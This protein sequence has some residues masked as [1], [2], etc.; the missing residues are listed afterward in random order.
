M[1]VELL[2]RHRL[3]VDDFHRMA[4]AGILSGDDRVELI[5]GELIDMAPIGTRHA[6]CIRGLI[7]ALAGISA[8]VALLDVQNPLRLG[9]GS[10]PQ[11][12]LMLLRPRVNR[13]A[14]AHPGPEDVLLLIEVSDTTL[15]YDRRIKLP[16]YARHGVPEVWIVD[17]EGEVVEVFRSPTS[18]GYAETL[19][20]QRDAAL[21]PALVSNVDVRVSNLLP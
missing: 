17:L 7:Q 19:R 10:E 2:R 21:S 15:A 1:S 13:Y 20:L 6:A 5:E 16:L 3:S 9:S 14:N 8:S 4:E 18:A 12:D 11:P